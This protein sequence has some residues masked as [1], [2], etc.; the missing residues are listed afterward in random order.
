MRYAEKE[1]TKFPSRIPFILDPDNKI[2]KKNSKKNSKNYKTSS[3]HCFYQKRDEIGRKREKK[4]NLVPN[5]VQSRPGQE[6][7]KKIVKIF[8]KS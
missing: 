3:R 8:K 2:P 1:K 6:N 5:S 7:S 4:N